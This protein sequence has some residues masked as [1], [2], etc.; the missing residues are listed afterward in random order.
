MTDDSIV[1]ALDMMDLSHEV[2]RDSR[3]MTA[4]ERRSINEFT[5]DQILDDACKR[6]G[7]ASR[8]GTIPKDV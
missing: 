5:W 2:M 8:E 3:P 6:M 7:T 1:R 4:T